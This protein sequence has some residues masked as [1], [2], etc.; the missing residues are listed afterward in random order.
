MGLG[1]VYRAKHKQPSLIKKLLKPTFKFIVNINLETL[2]QL[3]R[4]EY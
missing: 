2:Q 3:R 4:G 1:W